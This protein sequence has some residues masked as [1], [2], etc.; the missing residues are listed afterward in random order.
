[1]SNL[2]GVKIDY[3]NHRGERRVRHVLPMSIEFMKSP[4]HP[5]AAQWCVLALDLERGDGTVRE[6]ALA[7]V[8]SWLPCTE[9]DYAKPEALT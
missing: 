4:W 7:N 1:M 5:G 3:T 8:H 2:Q 9:A 6:F